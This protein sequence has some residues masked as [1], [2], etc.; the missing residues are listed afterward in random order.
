MYIEAQNACLIIRHLGE[1]VSFESFESFLYHVRGGFESG[2][3]LYQKPFPAFS[4]PIGDPALHFLP[5]V[6]DFIPH[7]HSP[8]P[9]SYVF[10]RLSSLCNLVYWYVL[11]SGP[12]WALK[13]M[14]IE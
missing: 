7:I 4:T 10:G 3:V 13:D 6:I 12:V 8:V 1:E 2:C 5:S 9:C 11:C 14:E